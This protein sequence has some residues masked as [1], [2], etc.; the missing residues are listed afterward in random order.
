MISNIF[1][2]YVC[3][4]LI[5]EFTK[6]WCAINFTKLTLTELWLLALL[7]NR[8]LFTLST[9]CA[10]SIKDLISK[11]T[12]FSTTCSSYFLLTHKNPGQTSFYHTKHTLGTRK[13]AGWGEASAWRP[14]TN[15]I[16]KKNIFWRHDDTKHFKRFTLRPKPTTEI[17]WRRSTLKFWK[18]T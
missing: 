8:M 10:D 3:C 11:E 9:K 16:K 5:F 4:N 14:N 6:G 18:I 15:Q 13:G 2:L 12:T 17:A 7:G 1:V